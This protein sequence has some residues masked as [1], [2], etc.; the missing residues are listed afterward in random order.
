MS[1]L[2]P[3]RLDGVSFA[4]GGRAILDNVSAEIGAGPSTVILARAC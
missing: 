1:A 2:L 3:L 4:A